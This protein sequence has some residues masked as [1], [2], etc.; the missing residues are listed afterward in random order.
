MVIV[1]LIVTSNLKATKI[2]D[3]NYSGIIVAWRS[4]IKEQSKWNFTGLHPINDV[5]S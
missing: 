5:L 4:L 1:K 3:K 2:T